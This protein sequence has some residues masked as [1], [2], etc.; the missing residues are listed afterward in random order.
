M[1]TELHKIKTS[2]DF[3]KQ[4]KVLITV[5]REYGPL[6]LMLLRDS[7]WAGRP[8]ATIRTVT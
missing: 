4:R 2:A 5:R 6:P 1:V 3:K 7:A 8:G